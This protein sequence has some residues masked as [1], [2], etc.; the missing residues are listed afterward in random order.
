MYRT[1]WLFLF[2]PLFM[3][4]GGCGSQPVAPAGTS[5]P[6]SAL[7]GTTWTLTSLAGEPPVAGSEITAGFMGGQWSGSTGCNNY[8]SDYTINGDQITQQNFLVTEMACSQPAGVMAQETAFL[9]ALNQVER[10]HLSPGQLLLTTRQ[11][12]QLLFVPRS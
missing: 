10:F 4:L 6:G 7:E 1:T 9:D 12:D 11:G 8:A 2:L 3:V 5:L